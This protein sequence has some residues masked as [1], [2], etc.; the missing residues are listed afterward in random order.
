MA[1][2]SQGILRNVRS[3]F[4]YIR[5]TSHLP[6]KPPVMTSCFPV[7]SSL[8]WAKQFHYCTSHLQAQYPQADP[9]SPSTSTKFMKKPQRK[10]RTNIIEDEQQST[11]GTPVSNNNKYQKLFLL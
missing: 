2:V 4:R 1:T 11:S 5:N 7:K 3:T 10:R 8:I 6:T 9:Q